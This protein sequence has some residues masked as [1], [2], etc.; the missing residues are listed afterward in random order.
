MDEL[1]TRTPG[2]Y[3]RFENGHLAGPA[4]DRV[5]G[6]VFVV[7]SDVVALLGPPTVKAAFHAAG[8]QWTVTEL[9]A[10]L[11]TVFTA[12]PPVPGF[13]CEETLPLAGSTFGEPDA[14]SA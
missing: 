10:A 4:A 12:D 1:L 9:E 14:Q 3:N 8:G 2:T 6:E 5:T 7:H 13:V 11:A